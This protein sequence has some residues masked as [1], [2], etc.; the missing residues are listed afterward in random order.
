MAV[1][2]EAVSD[3]APA[4]APYELFKLQSQDQL[5]K[6]K[7]SKVLIYSMPTWTERRASG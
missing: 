7:K 2:Q 5:L 4:G 1:T 6:E 3:D